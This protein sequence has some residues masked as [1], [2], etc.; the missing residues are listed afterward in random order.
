EAAARMQCQNNLKQIGI[1][2]H[3]YHDVHEVF[4][5]GQHVAEGLYYANWCIFILPF[6]EQQN[7]A[8]KYDHTA[9]NTHANNAF[10]RKSYVKVYPCP[11]DVNANKILQ[12]ETWSPGGPNKYRT[13]S[14]RGMGG[15]CKDGFYMWSDPGEVSWNLINN[16]AG[17]GVL[18]GDANGN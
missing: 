2:L 15:V 10:V 14:Y 11:T 9:P 6:L 12:P 5:P 7:L 16:P 8:D 18:H 17:K 3:H 4:P 13:G 1:A